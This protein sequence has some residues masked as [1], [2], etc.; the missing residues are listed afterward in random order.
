MQFC[1]ANA[2]RSSVVQAVQCS[3]FNSDAA[4]VERSCGG[5]QT[6]HSAAS[7]QMYATVETTGPRTLVQFKDQSTSAMQQI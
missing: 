7:S 3:H 1:S 5:D 2:Q 4:V 6:R